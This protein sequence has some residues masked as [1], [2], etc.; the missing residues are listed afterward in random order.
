[1]FIYSVAPTSNSSVYTD[2]HTLHMNE[3]TARPECTLHSTYTAMAVRLDDYTQHTYIHT[4]PNETA[5][6]RST[7]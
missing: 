5:N 7:H 4:T 2:A 6:A 1:M 3:Y